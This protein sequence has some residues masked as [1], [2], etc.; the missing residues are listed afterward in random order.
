M[1]DLRIPSVKRPQKVRIRVNDE[2][3]VAFKGESVYAALLTAGHRSLRCSKSGQPRGGFC[4]MGVCFECLV[5]IGGVPN[6]R[7]CMVEVK[8]NMEI[9]VDED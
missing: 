3:V 2:E 9:R 5:T 4:G 1:S 8:D 6:Q 7:A